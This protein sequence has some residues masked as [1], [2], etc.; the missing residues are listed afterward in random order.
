MTLQ[1]ITA[2]VAGIG[3]ILASLGLLVACLAYIK[4]QAIE[5]S[6]HS[7]QYMPIDPAV[8]AANEAFL[9]S[10]NKDQD[11]DTGNSWATSPD[12]LRKQREMFNEDLEDNMPEFATT[13]EDKEIISF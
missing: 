12:S 1:L 11:G 10:K 8:D 7:V 6:T 4:A 13:D 3:T 5:S 9:N 2:I